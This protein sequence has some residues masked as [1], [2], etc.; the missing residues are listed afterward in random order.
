MFRILSSLIVALTFMGCAQARYA[1]TSIEQAVDN[2]VTQTFEWG[3]VHCP[4]GT[5]CAEI[6]V[7]RVDIEQR[8]GGRIEV[9]LHN[10][11][12]ITVAAQIAIE[13]LDA[14]GARLDMTNYEDVPLEPRQETVWDMPGIYQ[15]GAKV[16]LLMR[17]R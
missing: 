14:N 12:H 11:T 13:I 9:T 4:R 15:P 6:E 5:V 16:R 1:R 10:R 8:D 17:Q 3:E 2:P 7:L